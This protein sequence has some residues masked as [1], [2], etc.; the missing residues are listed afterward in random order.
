MVKTAWVK[1]LIPVQG[2]KLLHVA[3]PKIEKKMKETLESQYPRLHTTPC[4]WSVFL[5]ISEHQNVQ[6]LEQ[7][8]SK[9]T[10]FTNRD[11]FHFQK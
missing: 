8:I 1:G 7:C 2:T 6:S 3:W 10:A 4:Y 11:I 9:C 5:H